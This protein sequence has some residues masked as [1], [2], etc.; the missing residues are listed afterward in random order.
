MTKKQ[1]FK[2][3]QKEP[4]KNDNIVKGAFDPPKK[5]RVLIELIISMLAYSPK[6]NKAKS[7]AE[8]STL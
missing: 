2:P 5:S 6:E 8:Y 4:D 7:I 1:I 3:N